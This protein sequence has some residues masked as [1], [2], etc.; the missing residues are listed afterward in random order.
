MNVPIRGFPSSSKQP[1]AVAAQLERELTEPLLRR[2]LAT[3]VFAGLALSAAAA[4]GSFWRTLALAIGNTAIAVLML[5]AARR[6]HSQVASVVTTLSLTATA[7]YAMMTGV[8][9]FDDS[10]LIIPGL[11]LLASLLLSPRWLLLIIVLTM[12]A[13]IVIG[14]AQI[15]GAGV[16]QFPLR[17]RY[18]DIIE[19]LII[20]GSIAAFVQYLV[21]MLR[22][23]VLDSRLAHQ[24]VQ[25]ILDATSEAIFI[26]DAHDGRIVSVNR[27]TLE[28]FGATKEDFLGLTPKDLKAPDPAYDGN[29]A[30]ELIRRAVTDGPQAFEWMTQRKDGSNFWVEVALRGA[31]IAEEDRVVAVVRDISGRRKLEQRVR[32][33]ETF[34]AVGQLAGGVAHDFN[35]QLVGILG[36]AEFLQDALEARPELRD[37]ADSIVTSGKRAAELTRQLLAFARRGRR[38]NVPVDLHQLIA[39]V[40]ALG[41]RSIDKRISIA[42]HFDASSAVTFGDPSALQNAL[43]NLLL[44][45]RDAMPK[46]G[47][48]RFATRLV[49]LQAQASSLPG[50][51][52]S[53]RT[54]E[55]TVSDSGIGIDPEILDKIFEPF[56]TTKESGTGMGLAAVKGTVLEHQGTIDVTSTKGVG[57]TF[58]IL[59]P[60]SDIEVTEESSNVTAQPVAEGRILVVDDESSVT[61]VVAMALTQGGYEVEVYQSGQA[62]IERC[63][64]GPFDLVL[65]DVM[66]PDMD[67]VEVL[68]RLRAVVPSAKVVLMTGHASES[69]ESRMREISDVVVLPKP[70]QPKELLAEVRKALVKS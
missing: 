33:A 37:C 60:V 24:S 13:V 47:T 59:L 31:R 58:R 10:L 34:R 57:T 66:M 68:Q 52:G 25:D 40:I 41:R 1:R 45:A 20:L 22:Q 27:P 53:T 44:N 65:L 26:H 50:A 8:G 14:V 49:E 19:I 15:N 9:I 23:I 7:A 63:A 5:A 2:I 46:G 69:L 64:A 48:V 36:H 30:A 42:E 28:M 4:A 29:A 39:E 55:L 43:L 62:V 35:N 11:F 6:G 32:E 51:N 16:I 12:G 56:F 38:C 54:I 3:I 21:S 70:F 17:A 61:K 18:Q 67:G